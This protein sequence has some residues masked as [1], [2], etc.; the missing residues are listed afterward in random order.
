MTRD[1][2]AHATSPRS[3]SVLGAGAWG[4]T[5]A[6]LAAEAGQRVTLVAHRES[7]ASHLQRFQSH[8]TSLPGIMIPPSIEI[9][10]IGQHLLRKADVAVV[11]VPTQKLRR[12]L[13]QVADILC[14]K[15]VVSAVKGL[16]LGTLLRP[17]EV[18]ASVVGAATRIA[19]LSGPNLSSEIAMGRPATTVLA[20][21]PA[22]LADNL[23]E[24]FHSRRFRVYVSDD[25]IG[26]EFGGALKNII[27]IGAGIADGLEAGD[28]AK[29]AFMTRGIAEIT[30]LGVACGARPLT[31]AGL[32]GIG[33]LMATCESPLSRNYRVGFALSQ[34]TPLVDILESMHEVAEG[35]AT[36]NAAREL[37]RRR[38]VDLPIV[39][40]MYRV[41]FEGAS[42]G[43]A[44]ERLMERDPK[45]ELR[46]FAP[47]QSDHKS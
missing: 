43:E 26:V 34:G 29:A 8:P 25:V 16:E 14:N 31:F 45:H 39:D 15:V 27:A 7:T 20:S 37:A 41:L 1:R 28:N 42:P 22:E 23:V 33:D 40:Q 44:I 32:S 11:A 17:S 3:V 21:S 36:T 2:D 9:A 47:G 38:G 30:R 46:D 4:T 35:V 19:V 10:H 5:L 13:E 6:I 18:I 24:L 12:S